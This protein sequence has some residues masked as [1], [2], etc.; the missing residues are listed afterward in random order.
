MFAALS[1]LRTLRI[2]FFWGPQAHSTLQTLPMGALWRQR[3]QSTLLVWKVNPSAG[4]LESLG[5]PAKI[6]VEKEVTPVS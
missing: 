5:R 3:L 1:N 4:S 6:Q 2:Q